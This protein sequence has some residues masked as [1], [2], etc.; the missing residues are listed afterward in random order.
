MRS[1][2]SGGK[3][4]NQDEDIAESLVWGPGGEGNPDMLGM[5]LSHLSN[6][7]CNGMNFV[8]DCRFMLYLRSV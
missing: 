5:M 7:S 1:D 3:L 8:H 2:V 4:G 6:Y